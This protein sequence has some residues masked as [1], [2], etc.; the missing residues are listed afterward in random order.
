MC[1]SIFKRAKLVCDFQ[2]VWLATEVDQ[3]PILKESQ[4]H[5]PYGI[6]RNG[7]PSDWIWNRTDTPVFMFLTPRAFPGADRDLLSSE[8]KRFGF[9]LLICVKTG[10]WILPSVCDPKRNVWIDSDLFTLQD[11]AAQSVYE[12][13][14]WPTVTDGYCPNNSLFPNPPHLNPF[15]AWTWDLF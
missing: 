5:Q 14:I 13:Q 15:L 1:G 10:V 3:N 11:P 6:R 9:L 8:L 2:K 4:C 7:K 12:A